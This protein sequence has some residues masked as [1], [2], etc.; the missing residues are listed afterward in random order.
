MVW[1][2]WIV[3]LLGWHVVVKATI[4][5]FAIAVVSR[6]FVAATVSSGDGFNNS[7]GFESK[8]LGALNFIFTEVTKDIV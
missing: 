8:S 2:F 6:F 5:D 4:E 3:E 1:G 7:A